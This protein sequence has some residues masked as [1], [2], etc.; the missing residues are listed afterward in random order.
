MGPMKKTLLLCILLLT[1]SSCGFLKDM[2][3]PYGVFD[4]DSDDPEN[5]VTSDHSTEPTHKYAIAIGGVAPG[6]DELIIYDED[7]NVRD[8]A[9]K[10]LQFTTENDSIGIVA[11][12]GYQNFTDGAG[13]QIIP[14]KTGISKITYSIDGITQNEEFQ[15]TVPPQS[16]IQALMGEA[17]GEMA[18]EATY[19][20]AHAVALSSESKTGNA[21]GAVIRNR[22]IILEDGYDLSTFE[23]SEEA[24][25]DSDP[26][27]H[28]NA[29]IEAVNDSVYQFSPVDPTDLNNAIYKNSGARSYL[30]GADLKAYDQAVLTAAGIYNGDTPD[31]TNGAFAFRSPTAEEAAALLQAYYLQSNTL[32]LD[33][34]VSDE[35]FPLFAP[36]QVLIHPEITNI[37]LDDPVPSFIFIRS[38]TYSV[39]AVTSVP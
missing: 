13:V 17:R 4:G 21:I 19:N 38:R 12:N 31:I 6:R 22:V 29:V 14:Q 7:K 32:P 16:L 20:D 10:N 9:G 37:T 33:C 3:D 23:V 2:Y 36:V 24:W 15:V 25:N 11:R 34:G 30:E 5:T 18:N 26:A 1:L 8:F 27:A 35:D 28:W 39:P